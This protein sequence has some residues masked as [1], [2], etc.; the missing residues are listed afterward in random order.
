VRRTRAGSGWRGA[1]GR[2]ATALGMLLLTGCGVFGSGDPG[3]S[4]TG[5][6][7][8]TPTVTPRTGPAQTR[9]AVP[10]ATASPRQTLD[11][12][13]P[14]GDGSTV[15]PLVVLIHGGGFAVGDSA[16]EKDRADFLAGKGFAAASL[17]YRLS[18]D[19]PFPAGVQDV[20]AAIR[21]L[22]A[23][24]PGW[25]VDP[26]RIAVWGESAGGYLAAMLGVTGGAPG[27]FDDPALGNPTVSSQVSAVVSWF[28]PSNFGSMD[29]QAGDAGCDAM[30]QQHDLAGSPES[31][32]LG[33]ALPTVPE[34]VA[35]AS[36]VDRVRSARTLP[37]FLLVHGDQDCTVPPG[38]SHE[39]HDAL[40]DRGATVTLN[41]VHDAG[42]SDPK[43]TQEQTRPSIDFLRAVFGTGRPPAGD[44]AP[45]SSEG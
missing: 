2:T 21:Y 35:R 16:D 18:G 45:A 12:Y 38:Q 32:W 36:I 6:P 39:L 31:T 10:Y 33:A 34:R 23:H 24:A 13:L 40:K 17:N 26:A 28:G 44:A 41:V 19:A 20:A 30:A 1:V 42:H 29:G 7:T 8:P 11:L 3:A 27:A 4:R 43:I 15:Y 22:R 9:T 5:T 14:E 25:G 37:P